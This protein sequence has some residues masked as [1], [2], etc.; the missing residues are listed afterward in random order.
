MEEKVGRKKSC[1]EGRVLEWKVGGK[2]S[3]KEKRLLQK[4]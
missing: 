4:R 3:C 1:K 2:R